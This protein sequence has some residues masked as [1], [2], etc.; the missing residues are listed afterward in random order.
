MKC[1]QFEQA[2]Q[3]QA[4]GCPAP[5]DD[6]SLRQHA[7]DC[8]A[9]RELEEG[10]RFIAQ[11]FATSRVPAPSD[12][13][14]DRIIAAAFQDRLTTPRLRRP[15]LGLAAAASLL[16]ALGL[17]AWQS[18]HRGTE[19]LR[20]ADRSPLTPG[21]PGPRSIHHSPNPDEPIFPELADATAG[22]PRDA[23]V[24]VDAVEPVSEIFRAVGRSLGSPVRPI[25]VNATQALGNLL[26]DIPEPDSPM[27]S[28]PGMREI[29]PQSM[30][31]KMG[32]MGPSS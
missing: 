13:L 6:A 14:T 20:I 28:M 19:P 9:C 1:E 2:L 8:P 12:D 5:F 18:N 16:A 25:A 31:K 23:I 32:E 21:T 30:K 29:M 10:F 24:L 26:K 7:R 3:Y 27:M 15:L 11:G 22:D 17:W 4:D